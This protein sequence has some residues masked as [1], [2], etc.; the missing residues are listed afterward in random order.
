MMVQQS[1]RKCRYPQICG[2]QH[3][4][5]GTVCA[6]EAQKFTSRRS[7]PQQVTASFG[8]VAAGASSPHAGSVNVFA[9]M[10]ARAETV[11]RAQ[12]VE[13]ATEPEF[14]SP[15]VGAPKTP[16]TM[17]RD[18]DAFKKLEAFAQKRNRDIGETFPTGSTAGDGGRTFNE[19][20]QKAARCEFAT[21]IATLA[22]KGQTDQ[23]GADYIDHPKGVQA[24]M[25]RLPEF[26]R[27]TPDQ[28]HDARV[29]A[30][31]HDVLEDTCVTSDDLRRWGVTESQ[32]A[33]IDAV[34]S[35]SGEAKPD[36]YKR[37]LAGGP[38][39]TCIK[40]GDLSHNNLEWRRASLE[41]APGVPVPEGGV[42]RYTKL[43]KKYYIAFKALGAEVPPHLQQFKP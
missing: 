31:L 14:Y 24:L 3:H 26:Q 39:S 18:S 16:P 19:K 37:V 28:Q 30:V 29:A 5:P 38:V 35:R 2:V 42:D 10:A 6:G 32:L 7:T 34:T 33:A 22:H 23:L 40:L 9:Q 41:G 27:L 4:F 21:H 20:R 17:T 8:V 12:P 15:P 43:G 1:M 25:E 11:S 36:Y 13:P